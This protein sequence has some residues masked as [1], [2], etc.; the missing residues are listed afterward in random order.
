M[1]LMYD[2]FNR[3]EPS[4]F[5]LAKPGKRI[6]GKLNGIREDTCNID[7][8]VNNTFVLT[9]DIDRIVDGE[10]SNYYDKLQQH[11]EIYV[12]GIGW[13]KINEEPELSNDGN[14]E[15]TSIRA[16][17][18]E[19]E[20]QQYD[21]VGFKINCGSEDSWEMM[22]TDNVYEDKDGY[23]LPRESVLFH[24][25]TTELE[26]LIEDFSKTDG[27]LLSL[28]S[29]AYQYPCMFNSWRINF[30]LETIDLAIQSAI[31]EMKILG[32]DTSI[33]E[34]YIGVEHAK[35]SIITLCK[36]YPYIL[37]Y[38]DIVLDDSSD[39][40][41]EVYTITEILN[42]ELEREHQL[43]LMWLLLDEHGWS[44]GYIDDY[45]STESPKKL[46]DMIGKFDVSTQDK[47]SFITQDVANYYRCIFVF[48]TDKCEV[49]AYKIETFGSDTN[50]CLNF[51]NVQNS[52]QKSSDKRIYTVFHVSN[53]DDL[54]IREANIGE[55]SI[56]D[57]SYFLNTDHFSQEFID[58]YNSW[59][60]YRE[61]KRV[62]YIQL[63]KDYRN[64][65]DVV[66]E[67]YYRVPT[68]LVDT[69]Q[70]STFTDEQLVAEKSDCEAQLRGYESYYVDED[71][72]FSLEKLQ[73]SE[74][75]KTYKLIKEIVIPNIE[76]EIYNRGINDKNLYKD[77]NDD[78]KYKFDLY[79]D[80]YGVKELEIYRDTI[81]NNM[82]ALEKNGYGVPSETGDEY[83]KAQYELYLK[84]K[85]AL[86]SCLRALDERQAE[87]DLETEK[88][89]TIAKNQDTIKSSIDKK[90]ELFGFTENELSVLEKYYIHTDYINENIVVTSLDDNDS[91]VDLA[92]E[93][94][95]DALE[96]LYV[97]SHPQ[98][99]FS[100]TQD[101]LLIMP[102]FKEWHGDLDI[103]N[104]IRVSI[105]D[106][107]QVKLR[108]ISISL[109]PCMIDPEINLTFS[110]MIQYKSK[111]NDAVSILGNSGGSSKNQITG[112]TISNNQKDDTFNIDS[113]FIRK[114]IN[115]G[116]FSGN[117]SS[118]ISN[119][120]QS[121]NGTISNM[122]NDRIDSAEINV[123]HI[124]GEVGE[125]EEFFSKYIDSD[126]INS[127][128][129]I[130]DVG[131]FKDLSVLVAAID[132]LLAGN[133][134]AELG[135]LIKL[136]AENVNIDEAVIREMI[137]AHITVAMLKAGD[138][139]TDTFHI[140]S[141]D[142]GIKIAG[143]TMQLKD[144]N[145]IVRIQIGRDTNNEFTFC[146][147]DETGEGV[148]ID[149]T[150]IH[151][152]AISDGIIKNN[153]IG[154]GEISKDKLA[155]NVV[156]GD[157]NGNLDAGKVIVDGHGIDVEFTSIKQTIAETNSKIDNLTS[158]IATIELM[159]EQIFKQ[160]QG[161]VSPET[162]TVTAVC[163]NG[164]MIG[165]WYI[166]DV[167]VTDTEYVSGD[168][169]SITIPSSYML[170]NN[171]VPIKITDS[172][173]E[174]YDLHTLYLISDSTGA[175][176]DDA[177]TVI[178]Q[179]ENVSFSV[180]NSS[181]TVLSDQSFSSTVQ[182]FHGTTER[183][184]FTIG[185]INSVNGITISVQDRTVI[186]SVKNGD[187]IT[188]NNGF[189]TVPILI[190]DLT[191]YKDIT[192]N[193]A[194]QG[195]TGSSGEPSLNIVVGNESQNIPC[196]NE[197][198]VLENFLIEIP[199]TGYKGFD[200]VDCFVS[201]GLLPDG[202]T[203]GSNTASTPDTEG[204]IILN[205][206][207]DATLG[208][209][210]VLNGKVT[211]TFT[212]D[213]K[214]MSRYFTWVKTKDGAE[215]SMILYELVSS[216]PVLNK[217]YDDTLSPSTITF[218]SYYRQSNSTDKTSYAGQ[219]IIAESDNDGATYTNKYLSTAVEDFVEYTPS[220]ASITSIRC[221]LCSAD[222]ISIE[223]DVLTIPVLTD[224]DS[225]KPII[226]EITTTMSGVQTQ[227]DSV[228][229][230][231]T[232]KVWQDDITNSINN[233]DSTTTESIRSRV[234]QVE[235]D[236]NG[237]KS[238]VS[239]VQTTLTEKADGSTVTELSEKISTLEQNADGFKQT[240]EK[241][242][243]AKADLNI[244]SRNLLR[245]SK[246]L[247]FDSYGLV[248]GAGNYYFI[249]ESGNILTDEVGNLLIL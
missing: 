229:K 39:I 59:K 64:Q 47:Y 137:A 32:K 232:D 134:S 24:R 157:G 244:S 153:M 200:R 52:I 242:Y 1:K 194:K 192:W 28:K 72:N 236:V 230:S 127:K 18:L 203:L 31:D 135:H 248:N 2:I 20:L 238:T 156:E 106:D 195:E 87:Y 151:E 113:T 128:V 168:K 191:F 160:I 187:K 228:E 124:K 193:L 81:K 221:T 215:G 174:L 4:E 27:T 68:D 125:F 224:V 17:S 56:E 173:G 163:R 131:E 210:S 89:N 86:D 30:N 117:L 42:R 185:E 14:T 100:T 77:F 123:G 12:T 181:N 201:V 142:G 107:Y 9:C 141:D 227:V 115:N 247:V 144:A 167:L 161:V 231:I 93:L 108:I 99:N 55:D 213:G 6:L 218:N 204:L 214:N 35:E 126:Y 15:T 105:R 176:G 133:F 85:D 118:I 92:N 102:E 58:K 13:F 104:F 95:E 180:D 208:G 199:F 202:V 136:T 190:D 84:Y 212:I 207:K 170:D 146:L 57:I 222:D 36:V 80:S 48:D 112:T 54:N 33:L 79:G 119:S 67:L 111:R 149:S 3:T 101:N 66:T 166:G 234:S 53:N 169:M 139:S 76:V 22:A 71:G 233:Y 243:V 246:T 120:I 164:A 90:N 183:T 158:Q 143:N 116:L 49:N 186:L 29:L 69:S 240:V 34:T 211:L 121:N 65:N 216:S 114:L 73:A 75:W 16:E 235:Q 62:E 162:I 46:D 237:I 239:D 63:S 23:K 74:D 82:D 198:L 21:L 5:Y 150:G 44:V 171:I 225:I 241:N 38:V 70:Y 11:Y 19:I 206:S 78:Y 51:S 98:W 189:F 94:Y 129:I 109:N 37:K 103:A 8:N 172:T 152:S 60:D 97:E 245:N 7:L 177:Y 41:G 220:S 88:L 91:K 219:F 226:T 148:L 155:F 26:K 83:H 145:N 179:N 130:S 205:V 132:N 184:D 249:D 209:A 45:V 182:I 50:I 40:E 165:D 61:E 25:D 154:N 159:G 196:S 175:K 197:G 43:S 217:N 140:V 138:I 122:V 147:Y 96:E 188:E 110:N 10:I 178:L 223:L